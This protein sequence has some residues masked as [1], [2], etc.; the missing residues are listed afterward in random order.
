MNKTL[1]IF[2]AALVASCSADDESI[3]ISA[4]DGMGRVNFSLS[5]NDQVDISTTRATNVY[6]FIPDSLIPTKEELPLKIYQEVT[7]E[8][9]STYYALYQEYES[10]DEYNNAEV[11]DDDPELYTS[12]YLPAGNYAATVSNGLDINVESNVNAVYGDSISFTVVARKTD[13]TK[14]ITAKLTNAIVRLSVT[15]NFNSYFAGGASLTLSTENDSS[16]TVEFPLSEGAVDS[17][18]YVAPQT[19]LYLKGSAV[20]Q[21]PG[22]GTAPT[23]TF[24]KSEIGV[25]KQYYMNTVLVDVDEVGGSTIEVSIN[26]QFTQI[27][28]EDFNLNDFETNIRE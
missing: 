16:F 1:Y 26:D 8:N 11:D 2:L 28:P 3:D 9:D 25:A 14:A 23:V 24:T 6:Y 27:D 17:V 7:N 13:V 18:L 5:I 10:V 22:T 19:K 20:K 12:P 21:D 4:P 15:E